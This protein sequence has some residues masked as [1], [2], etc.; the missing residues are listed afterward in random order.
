MLR[1]TKLTDYAIVIL[2]HCATEERAQH[3]T[4]DLA[5]RSKL[6]LPTVGKVLKTLAR[7]GLVVA[8]RGKYGGYSLARPPEEISVAEIIEAI[9]GP[10]AITEC[11]EPGAGR[12]ELEGGCPVR[13]NWQKI[14]AI[15]RRSLMNVSLEVLR[16]PDRHKSAA[17]TLVQLLGR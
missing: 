5:D 13:A 1:I 15:V 12:C 6:P 2:T 3:T 14:S 17:E 8:S 7:A 16:Q 4:K 10:L 11:S 9:E